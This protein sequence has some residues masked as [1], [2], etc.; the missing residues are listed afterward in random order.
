MIINSGLS[1]HLLHVLVDDV[2][3]GCPTWVVGLSLQDLQFGALGE[4]VL[5]AELQEAGLGPAHPL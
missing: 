1:M 2:A 4:G 5:Q 3:A